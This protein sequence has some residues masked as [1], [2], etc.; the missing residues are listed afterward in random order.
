MSSDLSRRLRDAGPVQISPLVLSQIQERA[1]RWR[2]RRFM[3]AGATTTLLIAVAAATWSG[4]D[5]NGGGP[6]RPVGTDT[7]AC[8]AS[9]YD[10]A[11]FLEDEVTASQLEALQLQVGRFEKVEAVAYFSVDAAFEEFKN[12]YKDQPEFWINLPED[13]LPASLRLTMTADATDADLE[14]VIRDARGLAGIDDVRRGLPDGRCPHLRRSDNR[15]AKVE[16]PR[17]VGGTFERACELVEGKLMLRV[18]GYGMTEDC[19]RNVVVV[20]QDPRPGVSVA[21]G[22][23]ILITLS[24][25]KDLPET[26]RLPLDGLLMDLRLARNQVVPAGTLASTLIV[27]NRTRGVVVDRNCAL[28]SV[29]FGIVKNPNAYLPQAITGNCA[30]PRRIAPGRKLLLAGPTFQATST[31]GRPLEPGSYAA[32]IKF[33]GRSQRLSVPVEVTRN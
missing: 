26:A 8:P 6:A 3:L 31:A 24:P 15:L 22:T 33:R 5:L 19:N 30:R 4:V 29:S 17:V 1:A 16:V 28:L 23:G 25:A 14:R 32:V 21:A 18:Q 2:F 11:L 10:I 12:H 20:T 13:A 9:N 7:S 27:R